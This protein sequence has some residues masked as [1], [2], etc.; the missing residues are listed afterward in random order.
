MMQIYDLRHHKPQCKRHNFSV[1]V[2]QRRNLPEPSNRA[3]SRA[4]ALSNG[5]GLTH[6]LD[7]DS[8]DMS[9]TSLPNL[10]AQSGF[11]LPSRLRLLG[12]L[13]WRDI[14][15]R[16]RGAAMGLV[17]TFITPI[18]LLGVYTIV[19]SGIFQARWSTGSDNPADFALHLFAG[20]IVHG[21]AADVMSRAPGLIPG[22]ASFVKKVVFPVEVLPLVITLSALFHGVISLIILMAFH[23]L[24]HGYI[25]A[26]VLFLPLIILPY[27][28]F[29]A[30][31]AWFVSAI[32]AFVRDIGQMTGFVITLL[33]FLSPVFYPASALPEQWQVVMSF[34]PLT[35]IIEQVRAV[36]LFGRLPDPVALGLYSVFSIAAA[37]AGLLVF[38]KLKGEFADVL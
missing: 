4:R 14:A 9:T 32:G 38:S 6:S 22:N 12:L 20:L 16:Y 23:L 13:T 3:C 21:L 34:N 15:S 33:L 19:F 7:A 35:T 36:V 37:W 2:R 10:T 25:N 8:S 24:I 28:V 18:L 17:W 30:G 1:T 5:D 29:L 11:S 27:A 26:T 31:L